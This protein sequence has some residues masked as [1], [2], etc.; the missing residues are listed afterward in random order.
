VLF[1][2]LASHFRLLKETPEKHEN[3]RVGL[4][5]PAIHAQVN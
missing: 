2:D 4:P 3:N 1:K 5:S